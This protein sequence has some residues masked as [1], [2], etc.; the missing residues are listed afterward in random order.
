[1]LVADYVS[2]ILAADYKAFL[3][4]SS[5]QMTLVW[6]LPNSIDNVYHNFTGKLAMLCRHRALLRLQKR[7]SKTYLAHLFL[8]RMWI[9]QCIIFFCNHVWI[10]TKSCLRSEGGGGKSNE[11]N[12]FSKL[13][14]TSMKDYTCWCYHILGCYWATWKSP[15]FGWAIRI[16]FSLSWFHNLSKFPAKVWATHTTVSYLPRISWEPAVFSL[17]LSNAYYRLSRNNLS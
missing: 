9:V 3:N 13:S 4:P 12:A 17:C 10:Q 11:L 14:S 16:I 5:Y 8:S 15:E 2:L 6:E 1:M 7:L